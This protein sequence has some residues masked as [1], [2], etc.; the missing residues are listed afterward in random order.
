MLDE[1]AWNSGDWPSI[2]NGKGPSKQAPTPLGG[3]ESHAQDSFFDDFDSSTL[4]PSWQ[5]PQENEPV[6]GFET[7]HGGR[8]VLTS[9]GDQA[10]DPAG[11]V[12]AQ[13]VTSADYVATVLVNTSEMK[14]GALAGL[15][16]YSG[17]DDT[18]GIAVS[19]GKIII[20]LREAKKNQVV[21][22]LNAPIAS[23]LYLRMTVTNGSHYRFDFSSDGRGWKDASEEINGSFMEGVRISLTAGGIKGASAKFEW[24][25]IKTS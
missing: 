21:K 23:L 7:D 1:V 2:N 18:L 22:T 19:G 24:I 15:S 9:T 14:T 4:K 3:V 11:A 10:A 6:I 16:A 8:L 5:W 13:P 25:R 17:R 12:L 20:Y